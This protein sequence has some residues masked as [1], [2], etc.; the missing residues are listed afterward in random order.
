MRNRVTNEIDRPCVAG[1][2]A[3]DRLMAS[4]NY[5]LHPAARRLTRDEVA[6]V[7]HALADHTA[8]EAARNWRYDAGRPWPRSSSIGRW[9][10]D[11]ADQLSH[12]SMAS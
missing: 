1:Q 10:H 8:L 7:L 3:A 12:K 4:I 6:V 11:V 5:R 9:L 2:P